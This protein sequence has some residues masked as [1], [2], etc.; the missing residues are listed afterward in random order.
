MEFRR[1]RDRGSCS[2]CIGTLE[3]TDICRDRD[4]LRQ[5]AVTRVSVLHCAVV[6]ARRRTLRGGGLEKT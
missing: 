2:R 4:S 5:H 3:M 6:N 1:L